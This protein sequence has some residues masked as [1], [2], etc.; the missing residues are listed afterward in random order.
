MTLIVITQK[1]GE[2]CDYVSIKAEMLKGIS[3]ASAEQWSTLPEL[4]IDAS[5]LD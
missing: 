5:W 1:I 2:A 4:D 3:G